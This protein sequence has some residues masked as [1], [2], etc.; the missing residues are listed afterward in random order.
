MASEGQG[1]PPGL[2]PANLVMEDVSVIGAGDVTSYD[3]VGIAE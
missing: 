2:T 3:G 1:A